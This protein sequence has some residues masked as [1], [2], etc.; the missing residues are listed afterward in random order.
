M[1]PSA[2]SALLPLP[3]IHPESA[4]SGNLVVL[5]AA[6]IRLH[7]HLWR[8]NTRNEP[9]SFF[10]NLGRETRSFGLTAPNGFERL[11][12]RYSSVQ[13]ASRTE[14]HRGPQTGFEEILSPILQPV[15]RLLGK[16]EDSLLRKELQVSYTEHPSIIGQPQILT[17]L[18][19]KLPR[20]VACILPNFQCIRSRGEAWTTQVQHFVDW[21]CN[22]CRSACPQRCPLLR[23]A[24]LGVA[25]AFNQYGQLVEYLRMNGIVR[26]PAGNNRTDFDIVWPDG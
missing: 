17:S 4:G 16:Q 24:T 10:G 13:S 21:R 1:P 26:P 19:P 9:I 5:W 3:V 12:F 14:G 25:H 22:S 18:I 7:R 6:G 2:T 20:Y 11:S 8:S 23:L 15:A